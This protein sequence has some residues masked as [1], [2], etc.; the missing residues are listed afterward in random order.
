MTYIG[1][2][3]ILAIILGIFGTHILTLKK[4]NYKFLYCTLLSF[5]LFAGLFYQSKYGVFDGIYLIMYSVSYMIFAS[6]I[7]KE[8][9]TEILLYTIIINIMISLGDNFA[10]ILIQG[11]YEY[12]YVLTTIGLFNRILFF[13]GLYLVVVGIFSYLILKAKQKYQ[14]LLTVNTRY[15]IIL[16]LLFYVVITM[17]DGISYPYVDAKKTL[18]TVYI[19]LI[20]MFF[21]LMVVLVVQRQESIKFTN[22]EVME[23][24]LSLLQNRFHELNASAEELRM[25]KHDLKKFLYTLQISIDKKEYSQLIENIKEQ[26]DKIEK[27]VV[28]NH[29][30]SNLIDCV[31]SG[32][33]LQCKDKGISFQYTINRQCVQ[34][35]NEIDL[36]LLL[37]NSLDNA[38]ENVSKI[39]REIYLD[40]KQGEKEVII[41]VENKVDTDVL[42]M[43]SSLISDKE[44]KNS[45]GYGITSL[46]LLV[47]KYDGLISFTQIED[48]F[49][50]LICIPL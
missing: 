15:F 43:N 28:L 47:E 13:E 21:L 2:N 49:V 7:A 1:I 37:I 46:K 19:L 16:L 27:E 10:S 31:L 12:S 4:S 14:S 44:D 45:H 25:M 24:Q 41:K 29:T 39:H 34:T 33:E 8:S 11:S 42:E 6:I 50:V 48:R 5:L 3:F 36:S 35:I 18:S 23:S 32:K 30:G 22:T 40:I 38:I 26:I 9:V 20:V 17:V